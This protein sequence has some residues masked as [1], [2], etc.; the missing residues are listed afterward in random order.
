MGGCGLGLLLA[1][2]SCGASIDGVPRADTR[3]L[4]GGIVY[5]RRACDRSNGAAATS[6]EEHNDRP[7]S[8][9]VS[10]YSLAACALLIG[11]RALTCPLGLLS[12][13]AGLDR[14]V[15]LGAIMGRILLLLT[16]RS[17]ALHG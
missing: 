6:V 10:L 16:L 11:A 12:C 15:C 7:K 14:V 9:V 5:Q 3:F 8:I 17:S 4:F 1:T 13:A 2:V